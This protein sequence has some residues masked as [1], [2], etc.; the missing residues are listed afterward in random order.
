MI[1]DYQ[2]LMLPVLKSCAGG[3]VTTSTVVDSLAKHFKL[4]EEERDDLLPSG[5][6][7]TFSN[8]VNWAKGPEH[9]PKRFTNIQK[10]V[11]NK[12]LVRCFV[13]KGFQR[14]FPKS[15]KFG[16]RNGGTFKTLKWRCPHMPLTDVEVLKLLL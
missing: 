16:G 13:S 11:I 14:R 8:R 10:T 7:T 5:K 6:Q 15:M 2:T 9:D 1:P 4:T 12:A 3:E